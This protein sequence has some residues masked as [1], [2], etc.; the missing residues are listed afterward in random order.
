MNYKILKMRFPHGIHLGQGMLTDG[1][2]TFY[3]DTL[4]S[5]LCHEALY[6]PGGID[7]LYQAFHSGELRISDGL[8]WIGDTYYLPKPYFS[9]HRDEEEGDSRKKKA[10]KKLEYI[11][12]ELMDR[13]LEGQL[14]V[15]AINERFKQFGSYEMRTSASIERDDDARP[16][17]YGVYH[18][19][20][21]SGLYLL[22]AYANDS[23]YDYLL[24]LMTALSY[25]GIGGRRSSGLGT[26][27]YETMHCPKELSNRIIDTSSQEIHSL[28]G[29][30]YHDLTS[31]SISLPQEEEMGVIESAAYAIIKRSGFVS[32]S[33]YA[34]EY[35]KKRDFYA[36]ASGSCVKKLYQGDIYDVSEGG[37]HPVYRYALPIFIGV[38]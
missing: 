22:I 23:A 18:Y 16:Y 20:P 28:S 35:M 25:S 36:I 14:D 13:Y 9:V 4:F 32:S 2:K 6:M 1:E 27:T 26:F 30:K 17:Q 24:E 34:R 10:F 31:L 11:P 7:R 21:D 3:A 12:A 15:Y 38:C 8:P 37:S 19:G 5:A 29:K 33:T